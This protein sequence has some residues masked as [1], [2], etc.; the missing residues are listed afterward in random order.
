M[1]IRR[2]SLLVALVT[3]PLAAC[4]GS[5]GGGATEDALVAALEK[6]QVDSGDELG[7]IGVGTPEYRCMAK[8]ILADADRASAV[9]AGIAAGKTGDDLLDSLDSAG[10]AGMEAEMMSLLLDCLAEDQLVELLVTTFAG[11]DEVTD[12]Q[13]DCLRTGFTDMGKDRLSEAFQAALVAD[14][15]SEAFA[16]LTAVFTDCTAG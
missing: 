10:A 8:G 12:E 9:E 7:A 13:A 1:N 16:D 6:S 5:G 4:G 11:G 14:Q 15:D 2:M 3:L